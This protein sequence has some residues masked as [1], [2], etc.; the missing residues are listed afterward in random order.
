[1]GTTKKAT[2]AS[3]T[4]RTAERLIDIREEADIAVAGLQWALGDT[5]V[6]EITSHHADPGETIAAIHAELVEAGVTDVQA[7]TIRTWYTV[8]LRN[9]A[10]VRNGVSFTAAQEAND[11]PDRFKWFANP[12]KYASRPG[13]PLSKRDVRR[14]I[15]NKKLD[16][17]AGSIY[18][19]PVDRSTDLTKSI[20]SMDQVELE[21]WATRNPRAMRDL[22][23]AQHK[24]A[25]SATEDHTARTTPVPRR[26]WDAS[27]DLADYLHTTALGISRRIQGLLDADADNMATALITTRVEEVERVLEW[28]RTAIET[29]SLDDELVAFLDGENRA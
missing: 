29:R 14:L 11:H 22:M 18:S 20:S 3:W 19:T 24:V 10:E 15:G 2:T 1:M 16:N 26:Q 17:P 21:D 5:L 12:E 6:T 13:R 28:A 9:P 8:A 25:Q 4:K 7:N 27:V 23:A